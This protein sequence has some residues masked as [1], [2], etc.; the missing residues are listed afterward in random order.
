MA[1]IVI[2]GHV[3][4]T[5]APM[6][7][8][9]RAI[10]GWPQTPRGAWRALTIQRSPRRASS[11]WE[12]LGAGFERLGSIADG[13]SGALPPQIREIVAGGGVVAGGIIPFRDTIFLWQSLVSVAIEIIIV[14]LVRWLATPPARRAR[15]AADLG[16]DLTEH[17]PSSTP[18]G[19][20]PPGAWLEHSAVLPLLVVAMGWRM[21]LS[22]CR[23]RRRSRRWWRY[24]QRCLVSS[25]PPGDRNGSSKR[26]T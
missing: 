25:S 15:T 24:I 13:H 26:P 4:A 9:I 17:Q 16:I 18:S 8:A 6:K 1:L 2:T 7:A 14:T 5:S 10:A 23:M 21:H 3:L 22:A 19:P 11:A 12:R 20:V